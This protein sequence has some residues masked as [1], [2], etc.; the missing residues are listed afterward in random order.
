ML[1]ADRPDSVHASGLLHRA[2][3]PRNHRRARRQQIRRL[4]PPAVHGDRIWFYTELNYCENR[5]PIPDD[6]VFKGTALDAIQ[7]ALGDVNLA[8]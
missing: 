1:A 7:E 5:V 8:L 2:V 4:L 6:Y 3:H